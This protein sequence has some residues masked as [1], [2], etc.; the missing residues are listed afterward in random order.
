VTPVQR[1]D[2]WLVDF[3][4]PIGREQSGHR[5]AVV[6][7]ADQLN[8]SRAGIVIMVPCTSSRR[9]LPSHIELDP[10]GSGLSET[11]YAKC[12]DIKSV[13]EL[14]LVARIGQCPIDAMFAIEQA[15]RFLLVI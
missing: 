13:S 5:P 12:E 8:A 1:G 15:L 2:V 14:R 4:D 6:V 11:T 7:S 9:S 3:G 10:Q